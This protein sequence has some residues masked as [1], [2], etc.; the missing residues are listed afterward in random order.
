MKITIAMAA[1][2]VLSLGACVSIPPNV[3]LPAGQALLVS[4]AAVDGANHAATVAAT[5]GVFKGHP[6]AARAVKS[7]DDAANNA[8]DSAHHLYATGDLAGSASAAKKA[9]DNVATIWAQTHPAAKTEVP[10]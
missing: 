10:Q 7:A 1:V 6:D 8:V 2:A 5:S 3:K 4:E 9:L